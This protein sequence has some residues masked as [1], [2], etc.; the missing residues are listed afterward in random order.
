MADIFTL[1]PITVP[2]DAVHAILPNG[3]A[4]LDQALASSPHWN[5]LSG[6]GT[7]I[8][9]TY[10][11][12]D[13]PPSYPNTAHGYTNASTLAW[14]T[15]QKNVIADVLAAYSKVANIT[16]TKVASQAEANLS[17][18]LSS[19]LEPSGFAY[20]P[21]TVDQKGTFVGDVYLDLESF[22]YDG[23][24]RYL[25]FHEIGHTLGLSHLY[26]TGNKPTIA[27]FD[28]PGGRLFSVVDQRSVEKP[29]FVY[30]NANSGYSATSIF[31]PS[32]PMLLD[33]QALQLFY[34][35]NTTTAA[36][37]DTYS[38]DVNPNFYRTIWDGGGHDVID[39]SNQMNSCYITLVPGTYST[40][41][42]RD[43]FAGLSASIKAW[44][45][46][47][48]PDVNKW[49]DGTN[50][51]VIAFNSLIE[52]AVGSRAD[53]VLVGNDLANKLT[54]GGGN[55]HLDGGKGI[56]VAVY[57]GTRLNYLITKNANGFEI[58][59][60]AE[61]KDELA[62]IERIKFLNT[63]LALDMEGHAG[64]VAKLLGAVFG[65]QSVANK[66]YAGIGLSLLDGGMS[67]EELAAAAVAATGKFAY[68]DIVNLLWT[69][70]I[71]T[72]IPGDALA[73]YQGLLENGM[74]VGSL[75]VLAADTQEN[76]ANI[77]IVG[78]TAAGLEYTYI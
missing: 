10:F 53:D 36:G 15:A 37:N 39:A 34:G 13:T 14:S 9:L 18:F 43:P 71:G 74:T 28:L 2:Y 50:S 22:P 32:G 60:P 6:I 78:L 55:D 4:A 46:G 23:T 77:N 16:F 24:N 33:V 48:Q 45:L 64:K 27:S 56:D 29:Y 66:E 75:T 54:G 47:W 63:W 20:P 40:I 21:G 17:F 76:M 68:A 12:S 8:T 42:L 26:D 72:Q 67:Y 59:S 62:A 25:A 58:A 73:F 49:N 7:A 30:Q 65:A 44:A 38:F 52:D 35:A 69:N 51:L 61:G 57:S 3:N 1:V 70:V 19:S 5:V 41:G 31:N 11:I